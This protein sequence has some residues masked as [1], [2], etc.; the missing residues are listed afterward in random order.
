MG[1]QRFVK[2]LLH[3]IKYH[4][5]NKSLRLGYASLAYNCQF[6]N[7]NIV[8]DNT[9]LVNVIIGDYTYIGGN[10]KINNTSIGKFCSLGEEIKIGLGMHPLHL[11]STFPGFYAKDSSYYGVEPEYE[12]NGAQH[13]PIEIGN[14]VWIGTRATILDGVK[15]GHGAIIAAGAVVT[16]DVPPYAVVGGV[17]AKII[18][19]RFNEQQ[20]SELLSSKWWDD[21]K[22]ANEK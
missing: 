21:K 16:K 7:H 15:V 3:K 18:K 5:I 4:R 11:R 13:L 14:D 9:T 17:P 2:H 10:C 6:G 8:Y 12:Y 1:I 22:Y 20:I 19:Y